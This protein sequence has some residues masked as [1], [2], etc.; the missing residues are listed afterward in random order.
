MVDEINDLLNK[1]LGLLGILELSND[2][3]ILEDVVIEG[4]EGVKLV[5]EMFCYRLVKYISGYMIVVLL[6]DVIVFIGGIG[7]NL[8]F[9]CEIIMGYFFYLGVDIDID[10]NL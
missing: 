8:F 9:I 3:W 4:Y 7:E 5:I 2:C 1:L 10:R 6:L